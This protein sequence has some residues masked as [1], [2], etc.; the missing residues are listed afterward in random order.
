[1]YGPTEYTWKV[2]RHMDE[3]KLISKG[4]NFKVCV[5]VYN[6]LT[7]STGVLKNAGALGKKMIFLI[8]DSQ[9]KEEA[10]LE[11]I[12]SLLNTGEVANLYAADEKQELIEAVRPVLVSTIN[13]DI[14]IF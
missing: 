13:F 7:Q 8:T 12:D 3:N 10:F 4:L 11:D 6:C 5:F 14:F 2:S 1:M 9:I